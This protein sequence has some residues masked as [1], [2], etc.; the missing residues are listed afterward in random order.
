MFGSDCL[1]SVCVI[2]TL[3]SKVHV[4][5]LYLEWYPSNAAFAPNTRQILRHEIYVYSRQLLYVMSS[6]GKICV[7][8]WCER[9][10]RLVLLMATFLSFYNMKIKI[11]PPPKNANVDR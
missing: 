2:N 9:T 10:I 3:N 4:L 8:F 11:I 5:D 6:R 7:A 1:T